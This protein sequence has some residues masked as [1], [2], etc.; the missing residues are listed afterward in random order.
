LFRF[1]F[2]FFLLLLLLVADASDIR[3]VPLEE[4][5]E[6]ASS[7]GLTFLEVSAVTK[8]NIPKVFEDMIFDCPLPRPRHEEKDDDAKDHKKS[9]G[10]HKEGGG[11]GGVE[12][13][14]VDKE[15]GPAV[16]VDYLLGETQE[17]LL[18]TVS[19]QRTPP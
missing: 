4:G 2:V 14:P 5:Q 8:W 9:Q 16:L 15:E 1:F 10:S 18:G 11:A 6:F 13:A 3:E 17:P 12:P 19:H 7:R